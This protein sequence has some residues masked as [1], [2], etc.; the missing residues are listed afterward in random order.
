[1]FQPLHLDGFLRLL[2]SHL[3]TVIDEGERL[4][5]YYSDKA[6]MASLLAAIDDNDTS[7]MSRIL[8]QRRDHEALFVLQVSQAREWVD[9]LGQLDSTLE[10][11]ADEFLAATF[12]VERL[13]DV[14]RLTSD[15]Y[16]FENMMTDPGGRQVL[17]DSLREAINVDAIRCAVYELLGRIEDQYDL[18]EEY[19][20]IRKTRDD[21]PFA[22]NAQN[23]GAVIIPLFK[24][25]RPVV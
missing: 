11:N 19:S 4:L 15:D 2:V 22:E 1:M 18:A 23:E 12:P 25:E 16:S 21:I 10:R 5:D 14:R 3:G 7:M 8:E 9:R 20:E 24:A 17:H 6:R 13:L